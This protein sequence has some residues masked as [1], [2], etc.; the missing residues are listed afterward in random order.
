L[1]KCKLDVSHPKFHIVGGTSGPAFDAGIKELQ[2]KLAKDHRLSNWVCHPMPGYPAY[3]K[4]VWKWDFE[5]SGNKS[6]TRKG[7]RLYAYVPDLN[8]PEPIP[9]QAFLAYDKSDQ[10]KGS[11]AQYV[12]DALKDFLLAA[13]K[14]QATPDRF[15]RQMLVDNRIVSLCYDCCETI[16]SNNKEEADAQEAAHNC[17]PLPY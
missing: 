9:A 1:S 10:P 2:G 6:H 12:A 14:I 13:I 17:A 11:P 3:D 5:P 4:K 8:V 16:F 7:W 15:R